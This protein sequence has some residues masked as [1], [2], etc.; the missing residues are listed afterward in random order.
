MRRRTVK[1]R[2]AKRIAKSSEVK[3]SRPYR[4]PRPSSLSPSQLKKRADVLAAHADM[5]RAPN[6]SAAQ[7]A[8]ENGVSVRDL[9]RYAPKAFKKDSRGRVRAV[10]DRYVRRMEIPGPDGPIVI[11]IRGSKARSDIARFRNDVFDYL[12]GNASALD[13]WKGVK[14]QGHEL[15]TDH[16]IIQL[17]GDED[18]L[19]EHFGSEQVIPYAGSTR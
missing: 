14:V 3:N 19:P 2:R 16:R 7:A 17:L 9:W 13:K 18:R 12:G 5:M 4:A 8:E 1:L 10:A 15:L 11:K 6:L